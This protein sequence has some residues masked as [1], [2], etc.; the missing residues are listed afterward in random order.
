MCITRYNR[1]K[2]IFCSHFASSIYRMLI[3]SS[4]KG[5]DSHVKN[6]AYAFIFLPYKIKSLHLIDK[7]KKIV[8][9]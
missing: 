3:N 2:F 4:R 1:E 8:K 9:C 5:R 6:T 7:D